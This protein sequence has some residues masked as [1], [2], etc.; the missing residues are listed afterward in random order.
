MEYH[1]SL[2]SQSP[3]SCRMQGRFTFTASLPHRVSQ[4]GQDEE[5][6]RKPTGRVPQVFGSQRQAILFARNRT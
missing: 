1:D 3:G 4:P 2:R 5:E 6:K